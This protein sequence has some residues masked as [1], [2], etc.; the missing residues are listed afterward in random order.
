MYT[1][2]L[3]LPPS[4]PLPLPTQLRS[5]VDKCINPDPEQRPSVEHVYEVAKAMYNWFD[6]QQKQLQQQ[7]MALHQQQQMHP[8][9]SSSI[10]GLPCH[11][12]LGPGGKHIDFAKANG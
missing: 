2:I 3:S 1:C 12:A 5:L 11:G 6:Q 10:L 9:P 7:Q 8:A 4:L